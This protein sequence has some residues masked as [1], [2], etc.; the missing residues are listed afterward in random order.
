MQN[1]L[2]ELRN[3]VRTLKRML[4]GAFGFLLVGG[5]LAAT[6]LQGVPD[7]IEAKRIEILSDNGTPL[8]VLDASRIRDGGTQARFAGDLTLFSEGGKQLASLGRDGFSGGGVLSIC[9]K[10]AI[11]VVRLGSLSN[12]GSTA[13]FNNSSGGVCVGLGAAGPRQNGSLTVNGKDG[14]V[15]ALG[16]RE[17]GG[18]IMTWSADALTV[19]S[20]LPAQE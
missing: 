14:R 8:V 2:T 20:R 7:V 6:S 5:F 9:N 3:Q 13:V 11:R 1:E 19:T 12:G 17:D 16:V 10:D 15:V 4:L 18:T